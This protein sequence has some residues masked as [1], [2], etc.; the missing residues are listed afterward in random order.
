MFVKGRN[1][2]NLR[3]NTVNLYTAFKTIFLHIFWQKL[4][5]LWRKRV[6]G[7]FFECDFHCKTKIQIRWSFFKTFS[8]WAVVWNITETTQTP[9]ATCDHVA[10]FKQSWQNVMQWNIVP[11]S[12]MRRKF[13]SRTS[14]PISSNTSKTHALIFLLLQP[15]A[16][17][18]VDL[19]YHHPL[20][21]L[22]QTDRF[23]STMLE[24]LFFLSS[25]NQI[26][27]YPNKFWTGK[28]SLVYW[29]PS[30]LIVQCRYT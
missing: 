3:Q 26:I 2:G 10:Y 18:R 5:H 1:Y 4:R 28:I 6:F 11:L 24:I 21:N 12:K 27:A 13:S 23:Y 30:K 15:K 19:F 8:V 20:V 7:F 14:R 25:S 29:V 17:S 9:M 16:D 22:I